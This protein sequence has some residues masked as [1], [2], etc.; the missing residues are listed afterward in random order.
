MTEATEK[1]KKRP[2]KILLLIISMLWLPISFILPYSF[3]YHMATQDYAMNI[4]GR[5]QWSG[6]PAQWRMEEA[7]SESLRSGVLGIVVALVIFA[8]WRLDRLLT[9]KGKNDLQEK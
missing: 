8:V 9:A 3:T 7:R 1:P 4:P 2:G 6:S 5:T